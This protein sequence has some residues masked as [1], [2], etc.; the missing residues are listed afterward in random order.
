MRW[1]AFLLASLWMLFQSHAQNS[2]PRSHA[3]CLGGDCIS[4]HVAG[5]LPD[6][7]GNGL[8]RV[9]LRIATTHH[10]GRLLESRQMSVLPSCARST[11][12]RAASFASAAQFVAVEHARSSSACKAAI[13]TS[14]LRLRNG[15]CALFEAVA[16]QPAGEAPKSLC[17]LMVHLSAEDVAAV[18][19]HPLPLVLRARK[20]DMAPPSSMLLLQEKA[21]ATAGIPF[22]KDILDFVCKLVM[23]PVMDPMMEKFNDHT[24]N[25]MSQEF[26]H[27]ADAATPIDAAKEAEPQIR[28]NIG[29][30]VPDAVA[31]ATRETAAASLSTEVLTET[32]G[33]L[34][35]HVPASARTRIFDALTESIPLRLQS[36]MGNLLERELAMVLTPLMS[37]A[38]PRTIVPAIAAAVRLGGKA[39]RGGTVDPEP[40]CRQ[41]YRASNGTSARASASDMGTEEWG[42]CDFCTPSYRV[43]LAHYYGT[44][45]AQYYGLFYARYYGIM[46]MAAIETAQH[47]PHDAKHVKEARKQ[48]EQGR[49]TGT[50]SRPSTAFGTP[51][52]PV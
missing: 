28:D 43:A 14:S 12:A 52:A 25:T 51:Q 22:L 21:R 30:L 41:C 40:W 3:V 50:T 26:S 27:D 38:V 45:Y 16:V 17:P 47:M 37:L 20:S 34:G 19:P 42:G 7:S 15:S 2:E 11:S 39:Y 6:S 44:Y 18:G 10:T 46:T 24:G 36:T 23:P 1:A 49:S 4:A 33:H 48:N 29:A 9:F 8:L 5:V 35:A 13:E 32:L 31:A